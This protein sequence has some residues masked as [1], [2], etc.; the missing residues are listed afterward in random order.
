MKHSSSKILSFGIFFTCFFFISTD[1]KSQL[2]VEEL[3]SVLSQS[4]SGILSSPNNLN[5]IESND[6]KEDVEMLVK[7]IDLV[8][9]EVE[10]SAFLQER[11]SKQIELAATLCNYDPKACYLIDEYSD[12]KRDQDSSNE[13]KVF[14]VDYFG[15]YPLSYDQN[16]SSAQTNDYILKAGD[17][18]IIG[19]FGASSFNQELYIN[20]DGSIYV[21][22]YGQISIAGLTLS[23][24]KEAVSNYFQKN[25]FGVETYLSIKSVSSIQVFTIGSILNPGSY[26]LSGV[27]KPINAVIAAGGFIN[28]SSLRNIIINKKDGTS[29]SIDLYELL[30]FGKN[31][32]SYFLSQ[33]D[34]ILIPA[35]ESEVT[36]SGAVNRPA[37]Y[38]I[39]AGDTLGTLMKFAMGFKP[40]AD[41]ENIS[42][43]RKDSRGNNSVINL[44][45]RDIDFQLNSNDEII[46]NS[47]QGSNRNRILISGALNKTGIFTYQDSMYLGEFINKSTILS[48]TYLGLGIIKRFD[49]KINTFSYHF[50]NLLEQ[51]GL[52]NLRLNPEDHIYVFNNSLIDF[53]NSELLLDFAS[54]RDIN[55]FLSQNPNYSISD[56]ECLIPLLSYGDLDYLDLLTYKLSSFKQRRSKSCPKILNE[57]KDL[58]PILLSKSLP[59]MGYVRYAGLYPST[60]VTSANYL[61]NLAGGISSDFA[62][63]PKLEAY[64]QDDRIV[65][66]NINLSQAD[67]KLEI[68]FLN[69]I[70]E[71]EKNNTGFISLVGEFV[72]PG[73]YPVSAFTTLEDV[74]KRAGG[75][76]NDAYPEGAIL[77]R[78]SVLE[79]EENA[80][81]IASSQ[82]LDILTTA[83][84]AG[85]IEQSSSD[86]LNLMQLLKEAEESKAIGR[87]VADL[88]TKNSQNVILEPGDTIYMPKVS[89]TVTVIGSV[90]SSATV[91]YDYSYSYK[92]YLDLAGGL[93]EGADKSKIYVILPNGESKRLTTSLFR[94][95]SILPGSTIIVPREARPLSGIALVEV[96]SPLLANLSITAASINSISNN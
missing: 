72:S 47:L 4:N 19:G 66:D 60:K 77:T 11:I 39:K 94:R 27:S 83:I 59:V 90:L 76:K 92:D 29:E 12:Y 24:A 69:V 18:V 46:I 8:N 71:S 20:S 23:D 50:F 62:R 55:S 67:S 88:T 30:I 33:G 96:L 93:K 28:S 7:Q 5:R 49:A 41:K 22:G 85:V 73:V 53:I 61:L 17:I 43:I 34:S 2:Q 9:D 3:E 91:P 63:N 48:N 26:N 58:L 21:R 10:E 56:L 52:D 87:L 1:L 25:F 89:N 45:A 38:E 74:Y 70:A 6:V 65:L 95:K 44:S 40:L 78:I 64:L 15:G 75:L 36:I 68:R 16:D 37:I 57:N 86:V 32:L 84:T 51:E 81:K 14:G 79:R 31:P 13:I 42:V 82:L 54:N 35:R 80:I